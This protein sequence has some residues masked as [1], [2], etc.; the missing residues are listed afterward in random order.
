MSEEDEALTLELDALKEELAMVSTDV[1]LVN[2]AAEK[3]FKPLHSPSPVDSTAPLGSTSDTG[4]S[5]QPL[6]RPPTAS[7]SPAS[8]PALQT[9]SRS[10]P[11]ILGQLMKTAR[12]N[13][14]NPPLALAFFHRAQ[15]QSLDSYLAGCLAPAY[16]ELLRIRWDSYRDLEG[17]DQ[18]VREMEVNGVA[19][20]RATSDLVNSIAESVSRDL[21]TPQG[22]QRWGPKA[23]ERVARLERRVEKDVRNEEFLFQYKKK[24]KAHWRSQDTVGAR[25]GATSSAGMT[26]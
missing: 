21:L 18:A 13:F 3:A 12:L 7:P 17:V 10:Y 8:D 23:A 26:S 22:A 16:N 19:W 24:A 4:L 1:E 2:W 6:Y 25:F 5:S 11:Q 15:T 20:N 9:F 14:N